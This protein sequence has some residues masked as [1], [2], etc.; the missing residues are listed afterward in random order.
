MYH[1]K[2][3]MNNRVKY[4]F[5]L[6]A[7]KPDFFREALDSIKCQTFTDFK[8]IVSDDCSPY[9]LKSIYD[10]VCSQDTRFQF[11]RNLV[12]MGSKSLVSHW[13]LLV[14][15]CDTEF[16][17]MASDDDVYESNFLEEA[18]SLLQKYPKANLLRARSRVIDGDGNVKSEENA[19]DE[20]LDNL[21]F[22]HRIYLKDW[23]GGIASFIYRTK[24]LKEVGNFIDFPSAW[25]SDDVTNFVMAD[26]G[27]CLT[28]NIAFNVRNS[29]V[30]ISG[31][32]GNPE[33]SRK[34]MQATYMNYKW[35]KNYMKKFDGYNDVDF[36][37]NVTAEYKYK[38]YTNVQ[39]Y[40]YS[41]HILPFLKYLLQCP[42][43]IGLFKPRMLAHYFRNKLKI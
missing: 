22:I 3:I 32:W 28:K 10:D 24:R 36:L 5:L 19:M 18:D 27:C 41:C 30:N 31:Q 14:D 33:D 2:R 9:D 35:M 42:A 26:E 20:W 39:S 40:I 25:F 34:K 13:N 16:L 6:P 7:Y 37:E 8:V 11:R 21:H 38:V 1:K 4:T 43:D 12:N 17:I 15:M 23:A 29:E